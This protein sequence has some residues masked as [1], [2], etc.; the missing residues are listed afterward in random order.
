MV[1]LCDGNINLNSK[2]EITY[3]PISRII[4]RIFKEL[5]SYRIISTKRFEKILRE[6]F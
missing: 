6:E 3:D 2:E 1:S 4:H 5:C